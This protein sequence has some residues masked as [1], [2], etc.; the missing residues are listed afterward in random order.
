MEMS[1][2]G[3]EDW[4]EEFNPE[5]WTSEQWSAFVVRNRTDG[6]YS[7]RVDRLRKQRFEWIEAEMT[8]Q[9]S[10][11]KISNG[12][13][14]QIRKDLLHQARV[15]FMNPDPLDGWERPKHFKVG[16]EQIVGEV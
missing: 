9:I 4:Q 3:H 11:R 13:R 14:I 7:G 12:V 6:A 16:F 5:G 15:K 2:R 10:H 8:R 1:K